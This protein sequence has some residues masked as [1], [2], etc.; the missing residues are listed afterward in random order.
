ML[1]SGPVMVMRMVN[2][3]T[4]HVVWLLGDV[5]NDLDSQTECRVNAPNKRIDQW[6]ILKFGEAAKA[7]KKV[8]FHMETA[9]NLGAPQDRT[10][11][12][13]YLLR[14]L[15]QSLESVN[16]FP[17]V[18]LNAFDRRLLNDEYRALSVGRSVNV[19]NVI[20]EVGILR[21]IH[22]KAIKSLIKNNPV[23]TG[24]EASMRMVLDYKVPWKRTLSKINRLL[25]RFHTLKYHG[26]TSLVLEAHKDIID[27]YWDI[28]GICINVI[29][30]LNDVYLMD[31]LHSSDVDVDYVYSGAFHTVNL[32][33]HLLKNR[34]YEITHSTGDITYLIQNLHNYNPAWIVDHAVIV[35]SNIIKSFV[36]VEEVHQC[37]DL[38]GFPEW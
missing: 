8:R 23:P 16:Q 17:G 6:F 2:K 31:Q 29:V 1:V 36:M 21:L 37:V 30:M 11:P 9:L 14:N 7:G 35:L 33:M 38:S 34:G 32:A 27:A 20:Q 5:H 22:Q 3:K 4:N 15:F 26:P 19:K 25:V 12:Y 18:S 28:Q 13:I 10:F 24:I